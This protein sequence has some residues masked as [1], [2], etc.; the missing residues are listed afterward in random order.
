VSRLRAKDPKA[1][2][3]SKPKVLIY[4]KPGVGKTW[5]ALDFPGVYY[6]D[7]EGGADLTH[8]TDKLANA[9]GVYMGPSDGACD[10]AVVL[11][12][13][14]GLATE[15]HE[16]RTVVID[17]IS[18]LFNTAIAMEAQRLEDDNKKNEFGADKKPAVRQMRQLVA[19][20]QRIDM[21]VILI[22]HEK[23]EWGQN[24][25]GE[26]VEIG[27]TFDCWD[28]LEYELHL[29]LRII[30]QAT[31]RKAFIRKT[32]LLGFPEGQSFG[33]SYGEFA[34]RYG[35]DVIEGKVKVI[36][37]A[38]PDQLAELQRMLESVRVDADFAEKCFARCGAST[39]SEMDTVQI[40]KVLDF[41]K[42][43]V[44]A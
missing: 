5:T 29:A 16:Y 25:S 30:K 37:L 2:E 14:K 33:W 32:R 19:W 43:K 1:A 24:S 10:F 39:W 28:K 9:G 35:R 38:T 3:P 41:L 44:A 40:G 26:R 27:A 20:L 34:D 22:A 42:K 13:I 4:G 12:Q 23:P 36:E 18:K 15:Q 7:T 17:S 6:I 8:Y 11:D 31:T 21:N